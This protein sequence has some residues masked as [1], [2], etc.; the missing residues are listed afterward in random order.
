MQV[1]N[2]CIYWTKLMDYFSFS[3]YLSYYCTHTCSFFHICQV[4][5]MLFGR[6]LFILIR[7]SIL[8]NYRCLF[9]LI[10]T[11]ILTNYFFFVSPHVIKTL[12]TFSPQVIK[13][14][15]FQKIIHY[16]SSIVE[17]PYNCFLVVWNTTENL[18]AFKKKLCWV[19]FL[20]IQIFPT[21]APTFKSSMDKVNK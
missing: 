13:I 19:F 7:N 6:C 18:I 2:M 8:T 20:S 11:S 1:A 10:R 3:V 17:S 9:I 4:I 5:V 15:H 12:K 21:C 14:E 16:F